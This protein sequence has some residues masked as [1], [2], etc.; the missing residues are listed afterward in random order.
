MLARQG[1]SG[2]QSACG[3][4]HVM[5]QLAERRARLKLTREQYAAAMGA[6]FAPFTRVAAARRLGVGPGRWVFLPGHADVR[7]RE[8]LRRADLSASPAAVMAAGH[9]RE[10]A[11]IGTSDLATIDLDSCFAVPVPAMVRK[12]P[13]VRYVPGGAAAMVFALTRSWRKTVLEAGGPW[14]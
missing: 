6:L 12:M 5:D 13:H 10:V 3:R 7:E 4:E 11:G 2:Q 8:F 9:A 1:S 14:Y